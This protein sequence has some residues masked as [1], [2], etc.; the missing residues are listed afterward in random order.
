M[1][2]ELVNNTKLWKIETKGKSHIV[3]YG[4]VDGKLRKNKKTFKT[5][6][7]CEKDAE[8]LIKSKIK[9]GYIELTIKI[10]GE[11]L[12]LLY[13]IEQVQ[14]GNATIINE[15]R[16]WTDNEEILAEIWKCTELEFLDL[17]T[18]LNIP[19]EL[20]NLINLK[21]L[22]LSLLECKSLPQ[23]IKNLQKL[24]DL[25]IS[26]GYGINFI[27]PNEI[28][29]LSYLKK[30]HLDGNHKSILPSAISKLSNLETLRIDGFASKELPKD[31][32]NLSQL[33]KIELNNPKLLETLP[34][35][36]GN[37][38]NL[39]ELIVQSSRSRSPYLDSQLPGLVIPKEIGKLTN[40]TKLDLK[41]NDI[42]SLPDDI[43]NLKK[44]KELIIEYNALDHFPLGICSLTN[45]ETLEMHSSSVAVKHIPNEF[46]HL[47]NL[48]NF[49]INLSE[50][51]N[52]PSQFRVESLG[53]NSL[54]PESIIDYLS[55]LSKKQKTTVT[56]NIPETPPNK[57]Q[58]VKN[59][60]NLI[61][62]I[63][64]DINAETFGDD[65]EN[66]KTVRDF[67]TG[68]S[69]DLPLALRKDSYDYKRI[70][71]LLSPLEEWNFIDER[72]FLFITQDAFYYQEQ[73]RFIDGPSFSGYHEQFFENWFLPQ[74]ENEQKDQNLLG[75]IFELLINAGVDEDT[76]FEAF[77]SSVPAKVP[78]N[79]ADQTPNS[80]GNYILDK[81]KN[82]IENLTDL[83]IKHKLRR[84]FIQFMLINDR[85]LLEKSL[86]KML[87]IREYE[88]TGGA[89]KHIP[90]T[91]LELL[92][93]YDLKSYEHYIHE[94][95]EQTDCHECI[96]ECHRILLKHN[97]EDYRDITLAKVKETLTIISEKINKNGKN[98]F[99]WSVKGGYGDNTPEFIDWSLE[100]YGTELKE[101]VAQYVEH[102][103]RHNLGI[104]KVIVDHF[105]Q[106]A[107]DIIQHDFKVSTTSNGAEEY[108]RALLGIV[109]R[110]DYSAHFD[111]VWELATDKKTKISQ[112][113]AFELARTENIE[114]KNKALDYLNSKKDAQRLAAMRVF[115][116]WR[117]EDTKSAIQ[118]I[119][120]TENKDLIRE[121]A[122]DIIYGQQDLSKVTVGEMKERIQDAI[123]L[124]KLETK[125]VKWQNKLPQLIWSDGTSF[126]QEEIDYL[127][128]RQSLC[129]TIAPDVEAQPIYNLVEK[130]SAEGF[131]KA[132][133]ELVQKDQGLSIKEKG[134]LAPVGIWGGE[135][136]INSLAH[137]AL[138]NKKVVA[139]SL[140]GLM[141]SETAAWA[142]DKVMKINEP[143]QNSLL[144][145]AE[146][147]FTAIA[148][149]LGLTA[150][151]LQERMLP[152]FGFTER[153]LKFTENGVDYIL[154]IDTSLHFS[155]KNEKEKVLKSIPKASSDFK[156][157]QKESN[158][159]LM[160]VAKQFSQ[161]LNRYLVTQK[162]WFT[163]DWQSFFLNH[164]VTFAFAQKTVWSNGEIYFI[165]RPNGEVVDLK[166]QRVYLGK[167]DQITL[168]HP[169]LMGQD[170]SQKWITYLETKAI[171]STFDQ[172]T[173]DI[174]HLPEELHAQTMDNR[175]NLKQIQ[176]STFRYRATK[177]GWRR[178]LVV[179]GMVTS[180]EKA[181]EADHI[182]AFIETNELPV[183]EGYE[184][185]MTSGRL[186]F[187][188]I[189]AVR[190]DSY[191][192]E[193]PY[194]ENDSRLIP[195]K[196]IP[197]IVFS[198]TIADLLAIT[199]S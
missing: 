64:S 163:E 88:G 21:T 167:N 147:A 114:V 34:A 165:A 127:F 18:D 135:E 157:K 101:A 39:E 120:K 56:K 112:M 170:I 43:G 5:E 107:L 30:L 63:F 184:D 19:E 136:L 134:V 87:V 15:D 104:S 91:L 44:L 197:P 100:I 52:I 9:G 183:R 24:E 10:K 27:I 161:S 154:F 140:L 73:N 13:R 16:L 20:G 125:I 90:F 195:F 132:W 61:E 76:C 138:K 109:G 97:E 111:K 83:M 141:A 14:R 192:D 40:L 60:G 57:E 126:T 41:E 193:N 1:K 113:A 145:E 103:K 149:S 148:D 3:E 179:G 67:V 182:E 46:V 110:F 144:R 4:K 106:D 162:F 153:E 137:E 11:D 143:K 171:S 124:N 8:K 68:E 82:D 17:R 121:I 172:L 65:K 96:M 2:K 22:K 191:V 164:P 49:E 70:V 92:V 47:E 32:G 69:H 131:A 38:G 66:I 79:H 142:L 155:Y 48:E 85:K 37:L 42:Q 74:L 117:D 180:Y 28:G 54:E 139:C 95:I 190:T 196:E 33:K 160:T 181:F 173:R 122:V 187:V 108:Y 26:P 116:Y 194:N 77:L 45:L 80:V 7:A 86:A 169:I 177:A 6:E 130:K 98:Q 29:E 62:D 128:Y 150:L 118:S 152:D 186:Y 123:A 99:S 94:L 105:G 156:K 168:A 198:E 84:P 129:K 93:S 35:S 58:L 146:A 175:F 199:A 75:S 53:F 158:A 71:D 72:V 51:S 31:L 159:L 23:S 166:D 185:I 78:F 89:N 133:W 115:Y 102:T 55:N 12:D 174:H 178:G 25:Y 119:L 151:E 50:T 189:G 81:A 36:I 59:R 188:A 176:V